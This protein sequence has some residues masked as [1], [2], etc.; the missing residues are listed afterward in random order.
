MMAWKRFNNWMMDSKYI[1]GE[2]QCL[3]EHI[4][5]VDLYMPIKEKV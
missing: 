2:H 5:G 3:E 4:G 1:Y